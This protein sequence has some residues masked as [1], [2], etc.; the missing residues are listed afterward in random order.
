MLGALSATQIKSTELA[1]EKIQ[2]ILTRASGNDEPIGGV[3]VVAEQGW[4]A[5]RP[6]GT[7]AIYKVYAESFRDQN[8]LQ[9]ILDDARSL[10]DAAFD[11]AEPT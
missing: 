11:S 9:L 1:G 10:V 6:S 3:K 7:E 2:A 4:F 5:A 8:H